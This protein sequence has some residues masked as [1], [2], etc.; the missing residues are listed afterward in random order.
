M[1]Y[2]LRIAKVQR[3]LYLRLFLCTNNYPNISVDDAPGQ[4]SSAGNNFLIPESPANLDNMNITISEHPSILR[5]SQ[6]ISSMVV[7]SMLP[8][9]H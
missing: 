2:L 6:D 5:E 9:I 8:S 4:S 3:M 1:S 7:N